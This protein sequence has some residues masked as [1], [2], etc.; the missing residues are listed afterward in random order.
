M[1]SAAPPS[2][3]SSATPPVARRVPVTL[4]RH[5][6]RWVDPYAWLRDPGY[7][8][9]EDPAILACLEAENAYFEAVM[10]PHKALVDALHAELKGRIKDDDSSVPVPDGDWLYH[11]AFQ[12]GAQYRT[13]YRAPR[14]GGEA[15]VI[16]DEPALAEGQSYFNLGSLAVSPDAALLAYGTDN[17]GSERYVIRIRD[18]NTGEPVGEA[19]R[20]TS[21]GVV[22]AADSGTFFYVELNDNLRPYR[23]RLHRLGKPPEDDPI[24]YEEEDP[25]FFV[26]L[27]RTQSRRFVIVSTGSHV[28]REI[29]LI[30]AAAPELPLILVAGRRDGHRYSVEHAGE[31]LWIRTNDVHENFRLV[32][33]PVESPGEANWREELAGDDDDYLIDVTCFADFMVITERRHGLANLRVRRYDGS[34]HAVDFHEAV[35]TAG[36]GDNREFE[37]DRLRLGFS[38]LTTPGTVYDYDLATRELVTL[39]VQEIPSGYDPSLYVGE[40]IW[41]RAP[42]GTEVPISVVHR[43]DYPLDGT[44]RLLLYGYGSYGMGMQPSFNAARLSLVDRGFAFAIAHV[45]GGDEMGHRWYR[46]GKLEAKM[47]SFTDFIACAEA[48][49]EAGYAR[50]GQIAIRGGSAGGMLVGAVANM[51]PELWRCVVAE[52]PFV[53]VLNTMQD[54]TLPLTPIEWPEWGNPLTS[55]EDFLRI[56]SYC[57]YENIAAK[58]YPAMLVTAG[59]SDPRVTYW[60]PAKYVAKLRAMKTDQN[61]L[62]M[63]TNMDAGHF[64]AS[65]RFD[66]LKEHAQVLAFVFKC[67]DLPEATDAAPS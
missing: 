43:K 16:L 18:L 56:R 29:R 61:L 26:G 9:V 17:D 20:N 40:R 1:T 12:P 67:F 48:L 6:V 39:K 13:W 46:E 23:V 24:V 33:T 25:A 53:D 10:A 15:V 62:L 30:E 4:E 27:G 42:D 50:P 47:N 41:A 36:L 28:T 65:G 37:A 63:K 51:R 55:K 2:A 34:E 58:D 59:I 57:P 3:P 32:W 14:A 11:W 54:E 49:I 45:R 22:W 19:I 21:G 7:P 64:G 35:Y 44:G 52:V 38:S 31:R 5:G 8:K 66:A 60:E